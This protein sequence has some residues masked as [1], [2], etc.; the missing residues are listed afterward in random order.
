MFS[1]ELVSD[2]H[3]EARGYRP[4]SDFYESWNASSNEEKQAIW[5]SLTDESNL[6]M[7]RKRASE[8]SAAAS[9][10]GLIAVAQ[11]TLG[12]SRFEVICHILNAE[13]DDS[14]LH[15]GGGYIAYRL[16]LPYSYEDELNRA[17]EHI[18][19]KGVSVL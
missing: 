1:D 5:D 10:E 19:Q 14:D 2:L 17:A 6:E 12:I 11:E 3:K 16:G 4:S 8:Q 7:E 9:F 18:L 13:Y 15:Y